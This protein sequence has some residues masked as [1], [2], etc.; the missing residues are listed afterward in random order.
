[1]KWNLRNRILIPTM[2]LIVVT[3]VSISAVSYWMSQTTMEATLDTQLDGICSSAVHQVEAWVEAQR[4]NVVHWSVQPR[5]LSALQNTPEAKCTRGHQCRTHACRKLYG[6][7]ADL[8][9]VDLKGDTLSSS[10]PEYIGKLNVA[11][12]QY[13]KDTAGGKSPSPTS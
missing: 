7:F 4:Q 8:Q 3:T 11:D 10:N 2:A 9:L 5:I 6:V 13:F 1:M 12:R